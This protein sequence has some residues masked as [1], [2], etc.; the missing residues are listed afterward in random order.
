MF[1]FKLQH[2][3]GKT[4]ATDGLL[5][6]DAQPGDEVFPN[7]EAHEDEPISPL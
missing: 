3:Q 5:C 7:S 2:V 6:G 4:F 1:H